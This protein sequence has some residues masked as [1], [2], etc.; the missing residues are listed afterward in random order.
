ML[1]RSLEVC[2]M[3]FQTSFNKLLNLVDYIYILVKT[4]LFLALKGTVSLIP[5]NLRCKDVNTFN[6]SLMWKILSF[7]KYKKSLILINSMCFPAV[8]CASD[9]SRETTIEINHL[10][11]M[12]TFI[13]F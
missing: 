6:R 3:I 8:E 7:L 5:N 9:L 2:C 13:G 12:L 11:Y 4:S 1:K 10:I